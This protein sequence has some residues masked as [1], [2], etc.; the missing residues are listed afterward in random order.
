MIISLTA[1][2][3]VVADAIGIAVDPQYL[4]VDGYDAHAQ[5]WLGASVAAELD[6]TEDFAD[7]GHNRSTKTRRQPRRKGPKAR[8]LSLIG[9][10][11]AAFRLPLPFLAF[12]RGMASLI[13]TVSGAESSG[14]PALLMVPTPVASKARAGAPIAASEV[15]AVLSLPS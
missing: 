11:G 3:D 12:F 14:S 10:T 7:V 13:G 9:Y 1:I 6:V 4:R 2:A 15:G 8:G 5:I